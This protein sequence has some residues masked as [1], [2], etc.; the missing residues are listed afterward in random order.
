LSAGYELDTGA[1][2]KTAADMTV[3]MP[4]CLDDLRLLLPVGPA[5]AD[6]ACPKAQI[7]AVACGTV[8]IALLSWRRGLRG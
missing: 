5:R 6:R 8:E 2:R 7:R 3:R 1:P 4:M